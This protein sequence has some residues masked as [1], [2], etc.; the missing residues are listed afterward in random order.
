MVR[1]A[2]PVLAQVMERMLG[3]KV[4]RVGR[5]RTRYAAKERQ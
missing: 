3:A 2:L 4:L 1:L 5:D